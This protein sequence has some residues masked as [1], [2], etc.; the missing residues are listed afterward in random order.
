MAYTAIDFTGYSGFS[1]QSGYSG[2]VGASGYSGA[3][4]ASGYSGIEG[5][6][7]YSGLSGISGWSGQVGA[8]GYS[9]QVGASGYSGLV[10]TSGYSGLEG[11]SGYSGMSGW[12][13][14]TA[15]FSGR[16]L[17]AN[18]QSSTFYNGVSGTS[19]RNVSS[20]MTGKTAVTS[21]G[22]SEGVPTDAPKNIV[23]LRNQDDHNPIVDIDGNEYFGRLTESGGVWTITYY[24]W[25]NGAE[26]AQA[27]QTT[28][29]IEFMFPE[30]SNLQDIPE[31]FARPLNFSDEPGLQGYSGMSGWSGMVGDSGYSGQVGASGYSGID[32]ASGY[33]G[34][35][36]ASGYSGMSGID[37]ASGYSG[38]VGTS[39][40]SGW[41]GSPASMSQNVG[42][43]VAVAD[44]GVFAVG[45]VVRHNGTT[46]VK[47]QANNA[48]NAEAA[49][50]IGEIP[51]ST[52]I[53][54][55]VAGKIT[56]AGWGLTAGS[57]YFLDP[58][59]PGAITINEPNTTGQVSK[60]CALAIGTTEAMVITLMR[61]LEV[62]A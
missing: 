15:N 46:Y 5:A 58:T 36:G 8:S 3:V 17:I 30:R 1:G 59:N 62:P 20:I 38:L 22:T 18:T 47:A 56:K 49:G 4:G 24:V 52:H 25:K 48:T 16:K 13:G 37:G 57:V 41:S 43:N 60:P 53:T 27:L 23:D 55:Y 6:S 61:G 19:S 39:G 50:M 12:S 21:A 34:I 9:G 29:D 33:S 35:N 10:G 32:G 51:D 40:Y 44:S 14:S 28:Q 26:T 45:D 31:D 54:I 7:G 2:Q 11:A 42:V